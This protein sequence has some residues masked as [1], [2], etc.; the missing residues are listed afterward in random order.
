[1]TQVKIY[2]DSTLVTDTTELETGLASFAIQLEKMFGQNNGS[3]ELQVLDDTA[4]TF[5]RFQKTSG[6]MTTNGHILT[7]AQVQDAQV[8]DAQVQVC[9][10][11][12]RGGAQLEEKCDR[13]MG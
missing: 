5:T 12:G 9:Q 3:I 13:A 10:F 7:D 11:C 2:I 1:M 8:Q 4:A 6:K